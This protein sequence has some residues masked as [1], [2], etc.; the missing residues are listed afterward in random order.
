MIIDGVS[1]V[2]LKYHPDFTIIEHHM[3]DIYAKQA[4]RI[5]SKYNVY[6]IETLQE[7]IIKFLL[8]SLDLSREINKDLFLLLKDWMEL[9]D[10]IFGD[11]GYP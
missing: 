11:R 5:M 2:D 10:P 3:K 8:G 4:L 6:Y 1:P 7:R 9:Q